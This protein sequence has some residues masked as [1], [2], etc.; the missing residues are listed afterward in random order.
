MTF[1]P[2][3]Q[4]AKTEMTDSV[5]HFADREPAKYL[6]KKKEKKYGFQVQ[7]NSFIIFHS[8][9]TWK[10]GCGYGD[11]WRSNMTIWIKGSIVWSYGP[12]S[13][14][15]VI[16]MYSGTLANNIIIS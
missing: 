8:K 16:N 6:E 13:I 3:K 5:Q 12:C 7:K 15:L 4:N 14:G 1:Y 11:K 10:S 2:W 9:S